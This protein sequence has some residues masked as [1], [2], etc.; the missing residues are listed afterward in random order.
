MPDDPEKQPFGKSPQGGHRRSIRLKG[1][2]YASAGSYFITIVTHRRIFIFGGMSEGEMRLNEWGRI[3]AA[4]W[5]RIP[6]AYETPRG[7]P[8]GITDRNPQELR[9]KPRGIHH[10]AKAG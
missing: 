1:Y 3:I 4:C 7:K 6:A 5:R 9:G 8:R 2:D 10:P